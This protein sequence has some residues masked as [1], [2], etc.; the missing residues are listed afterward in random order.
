MLDLFGEIIELLQKKIVYSLIVYILIIVSQ[1]EESRVCGPTTSS[2]S[3]AALNEAG[4]TRNE[5]GPTP[6]PQ[7][8]RKSSINWLLKLFPSSPRKERASRKGRKCHDWR[9]QWGNND[10]T[11]LELVDWKIR[12]NFCLSFR[13]LFSSSKCSKF[14]DTFTLKVNSIQHTYL[15][16][17]YLILNRITTRAL[18]EH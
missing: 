2:F 10:G 8:T 1:V 6:P 4:S 11:F 5:C 3:V 7:I 17:Y 14:V 9:S 12:K 16:Y 15:L 13:I 18:E